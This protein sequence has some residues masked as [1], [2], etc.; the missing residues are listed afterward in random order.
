MNK[1]LLTAVLLAGTALATP[2]SCSYDLELWR[3]LAPARSAAS[4]Q[5]TAGGLILSP[6]GFMTSAIRHGSVRQE[7]RRQRNRPR[8]CQRASWTTRLRRGFVQINIDWHARSL[9]IQRFSFQMGSRQQR[10][11]GG[12]RFA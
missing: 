8:S 7:R 2:A 11:L 12:V 5:L 9:L 6:R 3:A 4:Q 10:R 1:L